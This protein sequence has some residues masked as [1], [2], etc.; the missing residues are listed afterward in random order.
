ML[1]FRRGQRT[2]IAAVANYRAV[3]LDH[4]LEVVQVHSAPSPTVCRSHVPLWACSWH[5]VEFL[6]SSMSRSHS[7]REGSP[8][9]THIRKSETRHSF[10]RDVVP[11]L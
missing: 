7:A 5:S 11:I 4:L 8:S 6:S 2:P 3:P 1:L 10:T 9:L